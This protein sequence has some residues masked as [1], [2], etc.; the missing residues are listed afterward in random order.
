MTEMNKEV[1]DENGNVVPLTS[2]KTAMTREEWNKANLKE[3]T[4]QYADRKYAQYL[5]LTKD[6]NYI[7]GN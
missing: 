5:A 4:D 2:G 3:S 1:Y 7:V 6:P